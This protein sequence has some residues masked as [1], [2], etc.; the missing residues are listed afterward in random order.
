MTEF[1]TELPALPTKR[2]ILARI[3]CLAISADAKALLAKVTEVTVEVGGAII[4]V[5]RR[6]LAFILDMMKQ[7]PNTALGIIAALV[8]SSLIAAI[9]LLGAVLS[10]L[11]T[12]LLLAFG[13]SKGVLTD[14]ENGALRG[15]VRKLETELKTVT[16]NG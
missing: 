14:M 10:P 15:R 16:G 5:G 8:V 11:L 3:D 4:E 12:P 6:I 9:P 1:K 13:I 7:F 2:E